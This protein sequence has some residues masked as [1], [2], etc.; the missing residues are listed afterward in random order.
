[1]TTPVKEIK[2]YKN[3]KLYD[4]E[5]SHYI[6]LDDV[7]SYVQEGKKLVVKQDVKKGEPT[8]DITLLTKIQVLQEEALRCQS[9]GLPI[10][11]VSEEEVDKLI[12]KMKKTSETSN[13]VPLNTQEQ[14]VSQ[15]TNEVKVSQGVA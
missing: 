2:K 13:V 9:L 5:Q 6:K 12:M 11:F 7:K 4:L 8:K 3:R 10:D 14:S 1:M 15:P